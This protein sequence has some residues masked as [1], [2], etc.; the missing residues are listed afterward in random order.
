MAA[1]ELALA[2][3]NAPSGGTWQGGSPAYSYGGQGGGEYSFSV[4]NDTFKDYND[5][6]DPGGGEKDGGIIGYRNGGLASMF[7]RRG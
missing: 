2:Q 4:G 3:G 6:Y 5:P 7:T 1:E